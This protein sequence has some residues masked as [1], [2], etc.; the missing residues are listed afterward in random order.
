[1]PGESTAAAITYAEVSLLLY[2][3]TRGRSVTA[4]R[5]KIQNIMPPP[6]DT[7]L[8]SAIKPIA[9]KFVVPGV[10]ELAY[11]TYFAFTR[12]NGFS[13]FKG[14]KRKPFI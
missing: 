10:S 2:S 9:T 4:Q 12:W 3:I 5:S 6:W 7:R 14:S 1:M 11:A 8:G 13:N